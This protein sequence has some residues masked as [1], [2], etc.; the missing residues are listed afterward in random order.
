MG[1]NRGVFF[2]PIV[3][4]ILAVTAIVVSIQGSIKDEKAP[5]AQKGDR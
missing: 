4:L 2:F 1:N 3:V 5:I